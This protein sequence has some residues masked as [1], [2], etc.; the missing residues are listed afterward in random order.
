MKKYF[1][2]PILIVVAIAAYFSFNAE[3]GEA[4]LRKNVKFA[5]K[6]IEAIDKITLKDREGNFVNLEKKGDIWNVNN[7]Y[8]AFTPVVENFLTKTLSKVR[9]LG[10][11]PKPA[12][13]NVIRSMVGHSKHVIIYSKGKEI[14][15]YYVG[16][17]NPT[18]TGS[19]VHLEGSSTP[20]IAHILGFTGIIDPKF[21][22]YPSDWYDRSVFDLKANE[23]AS[24]SVTNNEL[25]K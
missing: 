23:I 10:P 11:V 19:Y 9:I 1:W 25:E 20:Y 7:D 13:E 12:R 4:G 15:N 21:S 17:P 2:V 22:C 14:R 24:I 18:Q 8:K 5:V 6:D 16:N 3:G